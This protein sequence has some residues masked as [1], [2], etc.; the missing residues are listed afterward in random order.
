MWNPFK[1]MLVTLHYKF[2]SVIGAQGRYSLSQ[3][4]SCF[5]PPSVSENPDTGDSSVLILKD[6]HPVHVV[7]CDEFGRILEADDAFLKRQL[8]FFLPKL[9]WE[10]NSAKKKIDTTE[11]E[12]KGVKDALLGQEDEY[13]HLFQRPA[14]G[15]PST[16]PPPPEEP[17]AE[18]RFAV[19]TAFLIR[20]KAEWRKFIDEHNKAPSAPA[21]PALDTGSDYPWR[22]KR[23]GSYFQPYVPPVKNPHSALPYAYP[24]A[25][26]W[27]GYAES[28]G[29]LARD[30]VGNVP[31]SGSATSASASD[32]ST[33][34]TTLPSISG[35]LLTGS[36]HPDFRYADAALQTAINSTKDEI[37]SLEN[38]RKGCMKDFEVLRKCLAILLDDEVLH[39]AILQGTALRSA[40]NDFAHMNDNRDVR[41]GDASQRVNALL[42]DARRIEDSGIDFQRAC[43][44][45]DTILTT[46]DY[47]TSKNESLENSIDDF[48]KKT[49]DATNRSTT[50]PVTDMHFLLC[51]LDPLFP[52]ERELMGS[53]AA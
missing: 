45:L 21:K 43:N 11:H 37:A 52:E 44:K 18:S 49:V 36:S 1:K 39:L 25:W 23:L 26:E 32:R 46:E 16:A 41:F 12:M 29:P 34:S 20:M 9:I 3:V 13:R 33:S 35:V 4:R 8:Y 27:Q 5:A 15:A 53:S 17:Q 40:T 19:G 10:F 14:P 51:K 22:Q 48:I 50:G 24:P 30:E 42:E 47:Y 38:R 2:H 28:T 7:D 31:L 6:F